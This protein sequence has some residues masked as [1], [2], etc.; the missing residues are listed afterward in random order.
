MGVGLPNVYFFISFLLEHGAKGK[1]QAPKAKKM[2]QKTKKNT[3]SK[4]TW[5]ERQK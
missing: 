5:R 1:K 2:I 4:E 3:K